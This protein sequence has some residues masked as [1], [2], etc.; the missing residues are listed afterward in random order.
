M[1]SHMKPDLA[2]RDRIIRW[3]AAMAASVAAVLSSQPVRAAEPQAL[4]PTVSLASLAAEGFEVKAVAGTQA[5]VANTLVLQKGKDVFLCTSKG[6]TYAPT[7]FECW[8][9]R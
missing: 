2:M 5:G 1:E 8:A 6:V 3:T 4:P 9:V 7:T